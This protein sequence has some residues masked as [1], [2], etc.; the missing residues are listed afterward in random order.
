MFEE[1]RSIWGRKKKQDRE[2][3]VNSELESMYSS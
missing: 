2:E 1:V 3:I